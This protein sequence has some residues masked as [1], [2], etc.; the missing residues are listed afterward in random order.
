MTEADPL[1]DLIERTLAE[2]DMVPAEVSRQVVGNPYLIYSFRKNSFNPRY[3][4]LRALCDVL[5]LEFYI[6]PPRD[7]SAAETLDRPP[8][9]RAV[10]AFLDL[11]EDADGYS[12]VKAIRDRLKREAGPYHA[13]AIEEELIKRL[14]AIAA[15][16][17]PPPDPSGDDAAPDTDHPDA[18]P[19]TPTPVDQRG[20][21]VRMLRDVKAAAGD[22]ADVFEETEIAITIPVGALPPGVNPQNVVALRAEGASMEPNIHSGDVLVIDH[23]DR[24]PREGRMCVL[25]TETGIVVKRMRRKNRRW[26]MTSDNPDW[27]PRMI[28]E[29]DR[30]LGRVVWLGSENALT[31]GG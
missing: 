3:V 20:L 23:D 27:P 26:Q 16:L 12:V 9:P 31:A 7:G 19:G 18:L 15:R 13:L 24:E 22:G 1:L 5:G 6:G 2:K 21:V 11:P 14:D 30:I 29:D 8:V 28:T 10:T 17:P 25:M 4:T